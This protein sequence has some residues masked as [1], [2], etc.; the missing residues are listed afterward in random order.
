MTAV[1]RDV[2]SAD[3]TPALL[4]QWADALAS[5]A[6]PEEILAQ[7]PVP[8]WV[9]PPAMFRVDTEAL[10]AAPPADTPSHLAALE[11]LGAGGTV[12]DVGCGGGGSSLPLA[13]ATT[14]LTGVDEQ[15]AMLTQMGEAAAALGVPH[16]EVLGRWP[17]VAEQAPVAD[18]VVCHHVAYNVA[19]IGPFLRELTA[20]ARRRVVVEL[21]ERHPTSPFNPLWKRF[22]GI[23]R[24]TEPS[25]DLFVRIVQALGWE[26]TVVTWERP[27]RKQRALDDAGYAAFV[28]QRLCLTEDCDADIA[29]ALAEEPMLPVLGLVTVSWQGAAQ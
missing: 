13:A 4:Q 25:A 2:S 14:H 8:P 11:A 17:D 21:P 22:W 23:D 10:Q 19:D 18:V 16:S 27:S 26:P 15:Q 7:A 28:R 1:T 3:A 12:L 9:H 6:V 29:A 24:P 20:H 5:W